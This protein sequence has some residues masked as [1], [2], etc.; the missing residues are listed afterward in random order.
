VR[1]AVGR[2]VGSA[3]VGLDH[4]FEP[5]VE[6]RIALGGALA[7]FRADLLQSLFEEADVGLAG[8]QFGVEQFA[9]RLAELGS[10]AVA[11][12]RILGGAEA[13]GRVPREEL[14]PLLLERLLEGGLVGFLE[15]LELADL[16]TEPSAQGAEARGV[17]ECSRS[18]SA[19]VRG[20]GAPSSR[21]GV[22]AD[23][24]AP[25]PASGPGAPGS[26]GSP[27]AAGAIRSI[28]INPR[29]SQC[30]VVSYRAYP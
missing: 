19:D 8:R 5:L 30:M 28:A 17:Q 21:L 2:P 7:K 1:P 14:E 13:V 9:D 15:G 20:F 3:R 27:R 22:V 6:N 4:L 23:S 12:G 24:P 16:E 25:F 11:F 10:E 18:R 26:A 29:L